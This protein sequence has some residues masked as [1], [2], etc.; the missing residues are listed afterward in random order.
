MIQLFVGAAAELAAAPTNNWITNGGSLSNQRYSPLD[1]ITSANVSKLG[2]VWHV[3][4]RGS[5]LAAKYSAESQPLVYNSTI[6]VPTGQDDVF[7]V[8]AETG[9]IRWEYKANLDRG[10][11]SSAAAGSHA[12]S[13]SATA[14]CTSANWTASSSLSTSRPARSP[15]A[16]S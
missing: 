5:G 6:Y 10:S 12:A 11:A 4:L 14:R 9:K 15:G 13:R 3:H 2:G 8:D 16:P 7:A 1:Q